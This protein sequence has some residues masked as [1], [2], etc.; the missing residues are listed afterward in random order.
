MHVTVSCRSLKHISWCSSLPQEQT[1]GVGW[2]LPY[3]WYHD[4]TKYRRS[5][6][7]KRKAT[8][9]YMVS[10]PYTSI[11]DKLVDEQTCVYCW[12]RPPMMVANILQS[13]IKT[14]LGYYKYWDIHAV[15]TWILNKHIDKCAKQTQMAV[16]ATPSHDGHRSGKIVWALFA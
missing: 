9:G 15:E 16:H 4:G 6:E 5:T 10:G 11:F 2:L 8:W 12:A 14:L 1:A 13:S 3:Q 7:N